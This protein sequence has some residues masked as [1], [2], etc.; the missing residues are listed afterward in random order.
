MGSIWTPG[1]HAGQPKRVVLHGYIEH[2][3]YHKLQGS[4]SVLLR[5]PDGSNRVAAL[6]KESVTFHGR[7][8]HQL[9]AGEIDAE[10]EKTAELFCRAQ[11]KKIRLEMDEDQA[12]GPA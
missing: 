8:H 1:G 9:S 5:M 11:G 10:M 7:Q 4:I 12:T 3:V 6:N 2:A